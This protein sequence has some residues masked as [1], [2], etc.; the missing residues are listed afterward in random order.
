MSA[1]A[2]WLALVLEYWRALLGER[3][4][5]ARE[6]RGQVFDHE[7][8]RKPQHAIAQFAQLAVPAGVRPRPLRVIARSTSTSSRADGAQKSAMYP[9]N[10]N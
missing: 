7:L 8:R 9:P 10:T 3:R 4:S 5:H 6:G 2:C 1:L